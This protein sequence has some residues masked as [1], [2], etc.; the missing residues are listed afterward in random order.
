MSEETLSKEEQILKIMKKV[1]TDIARETHTTPGF[2]HPLSDQTLLNMR[3]CLVLITARE[4]ELAQA[5]GR[6][7]IARPRFIDEVPQNVVVDFEN[8][9]KNDED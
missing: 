7:S 2:K 4:S 5:A 9:S 1:I 3:E 8:K 6:E